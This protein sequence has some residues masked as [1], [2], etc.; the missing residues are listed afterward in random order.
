MKHPLLLALLLVSALPTFAEELRTF[1]NQEGK[2]LQAALVSHRGDGESLRL[3]L[4]NGELVEVGLDLF[5]EADQDHIREWM[6]VTPA[7]IDYKLS[8]K[9]QKVKLDT[10]HRDTSGFFESEVKE[11][12]YDIAIQ[13]QG[14]EEVPGFTVEYQILV[15]PGSL[16]GVRS[17]AIKRTEGE[18]EQ[19]TALG[20]RRGLAFQTA[21]FTLRSM[22]AGAR[23]ESADEL[24]GLLVRVVNSEGIVIQEFESGGA[25]LAGQEWGETEATRGKG[26]R[27]R[28]GLFR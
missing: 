3:R 7:Q 13:N 4:E 12:A 17:L 27:K 11:F 15:R 10:L 6:A 2:S 24:L 21:P 23:N 18:H 19:A 20:S 26:L 28:L 25:G 8:I 22:E 5:S 14:H 16:R 1:R 9:A